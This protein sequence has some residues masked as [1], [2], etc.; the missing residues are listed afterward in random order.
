VANHQR[1]GFSLST[2]GDKSA[3]RGSERLHHLTLSD[4][5]NETVWQ[6]CR[7]RDSKP[8]AGTLH[9]AHQVQG[10]TTTVCGCSTPASRPY[11]GHR[12]RVC[13]RT[14]TATPT[15]SAVPTAGCR[16]ATCAPLAPASSST[17]VRVSK[18][19]NQA[20]GRRRPRMPPP[21]RPATRRRSRRW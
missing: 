9:P 18:L 4:G 12:S 11:A 6:P 8:F 14:T 2:S 1:I 3:Y 15:R 13:S 5:V 19:F 7:R 10:P 20:S 16:K 21:A 17:A